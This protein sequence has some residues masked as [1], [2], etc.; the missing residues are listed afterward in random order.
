MNDSFELSELLACVLTFTRVELEAVLNDPHHTSEQIVALLEKDFSDLL[1]ASV[2]VWEEYT[3]RQHSLMV[4]NQFRRYF[5]SDDVP[6]S[7]EYRFLEIVFL[8]H[9]FG[10]PIAWAKKERNAQHAYTIPLLKRF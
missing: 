4:A 7:I 9:D 2:G 5:R 8:L 10:K 3:L 6:V 1:Q